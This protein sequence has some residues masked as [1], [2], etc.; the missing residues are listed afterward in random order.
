MPAPPIE[1]AATIPAPP[2]PATEPSSAI[3]EPAT[4]FALLSPP[5]M[6]TLPPQPQAAPTTPQE[7]AV[8]TA[9]TAKKDSEPKP[10]FDPATHPPSGL[11]VKPA[12][13]SVDTASFG[14]SKAVLIR[15]EDGRDLR[16]I[17][18]SVLEGFEKSM[19][20]SFIRSRAEGGQSLGEFPT[21]EAALAKA[22]E[23]CPSP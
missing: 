14:G 9:P 13:C 1:T 12:T 4:H 8:G 10:A 3:D 18:V 5:A 20:E 19:A 7:P 23:L 21:K 11:G 17:A 15:A 22:R 6:L 2:A 16:F